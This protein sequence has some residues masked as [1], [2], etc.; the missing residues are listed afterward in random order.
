[1]PEF[2]QIFT[3]LGALTVEYVRDEVDKVVQEC[4]E[5]AFL[6]LLA[7]PDYAHHMRALLPASPRKS[8]RDPDPD[9]PTFVV[10][11]AAQV[12]R[13]LQEVQA[14]AAEP[15]EPDEPSGADE[16]EEAAELAPSTSPLSLDLSTV[17]GWSEEE[18]MILV[19]KLFRG[20]QVDGDEGEGFPLVRSHSDDE[21]IEAA[22]EKMPRRGPLDRVIDIES[23]VNEKINR[24]LHA[25]FYNAPG[26]HQ[27]FQHRKK[28][29]GVINTD[30]NP[31]PV[32]LVQ[33][34]K[35]TES[36]KTRRENRARSISSLKQ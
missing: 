7:R 2:E 16:I 6:E 33:E 1:M 8:P 3:D 11:P 36:A 13:E 9:G 10:D 25:G 35:K 20:L 14:H 23:V 22:L 12:I 24:L 27:L 34:M 29:V 18:K 17:Q 31:I 19:Q 21:A 4:I 28:S 26:I 5:K 15:D 32:V 30:Q